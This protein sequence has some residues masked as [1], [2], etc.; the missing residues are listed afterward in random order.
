M[1]H[2]FRT[3][4]IQLLRLQSYIKVSDLVNFVTTNVRNFVIAHCSLGLKRLKGIILDRQILERVPYL[5]FKFARNANY[6]LLTL[7]LHYD[8]V[9]QNVG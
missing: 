8:G 5:L 7:M 2:H 6:K 9:Y 4:L 1:K 3:P